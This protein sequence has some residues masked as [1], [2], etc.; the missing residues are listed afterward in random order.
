MRSW[1]AG[2][3]Q[4]LA[5]WLPWSPYVRVSIII[6]RRELS[7]F[8]QFQTNSTSYWVA[9]AKGQRIASKEVK[10]T[11]REAELFHSIGTE[12]KNSCSHTFI[13]QFAFIFLNTS[14]R[15]LYIVEII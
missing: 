14:L 11:R 1:L 8:H 3:S 6:R 12:I 9:C 4:S 13:L 2:L 5:Q 10:E 7:D 15:A